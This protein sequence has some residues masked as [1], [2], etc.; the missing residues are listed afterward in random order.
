MESAMALF[1][2]GFILLLVAIFGTRSSSQLA[3]AKGILS[4]IG[5]A[6]MAIGFFSSAIRQIEAGNVG[7]KVLFGKVEEGILPEGLHVVNPLLDVKEMSVRTQNYTM[8]ATT[9]EG[10]VVGDDAI[11]VL[12]KDG[13]EV[14][15]DLTILYRVIDNMAPNIY[16]EL[17]LD[18]Q[19]KIIRPITR[20][21]IREA[22]SNYDAIS[23][24]SEKREEFE[25]KVMVKIEKNLKDRGV[26]LEKL[27]VRNIQLPNSVKQSIERKITAVQE[28]QRMKYVLEKELQ[29]AERKRVEAQGNADA[30]RIVASALTDKVLQ[31]EMIKVQKELVNS[32]NAKIIM[33][34]NSKNSPPFIIGK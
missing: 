6:L 17:G 15:I 8:S 3:K 20:T 23:L 32:P 30:Q 34:G 31:F 28:S 1:I 33:L 22:A 26:E 5:I 16:R 24:F 12:S 7:V 25:S 21:G 18:Y 11:R 13:L 10:G 29:E 9:G 14:V 4:I 19:D 27:L 2:L